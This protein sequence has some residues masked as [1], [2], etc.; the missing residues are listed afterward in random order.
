MAFLGQQSRHEQQRI[1]RFNTWFRA[2]PVVAVLSPLLGLLAIVDFFTIVIGGAAGA[3]AIVTGVMG[4]RQLRNAPG[5]PGLTLCVAGI[6]TGIVGL[7][8]TGLFVAFVVLK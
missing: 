5:Q 4:I 1:E 6:I 2:R 8:L 3:A 7:A